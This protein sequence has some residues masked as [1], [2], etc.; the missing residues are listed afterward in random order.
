MEG[1]RLKLQKQLVYM[2]SDLS[3][4]KVGS[5]PEKHQSHAVS[6][7]TCVAAQHQQHSLLLALS[8][9]SS[10]AV[11]PF[12]DVIRPLVSLSSTY[13]HNYVISLWYKKE[14]KKEVIRFELTIPCALLE[15]WGETL[16][17]DD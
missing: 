15:D 5:L 4:N 6:T 9:Y 3:L 12:L 17:D 1:I 10:T 11:Y 2:I 16:N 8:V 13:R 7:M 14:K